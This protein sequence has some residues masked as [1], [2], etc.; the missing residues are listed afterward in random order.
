M[1]PPFSLRTALILGLGFLGITV[2]E[3]IFNIF[4]PLFLKEAGLSATVVGF[5]MTWDNYINMVVQPVAG[6]CSDRTRTRFGRRKPW[7]LVGAP[8]AAIG[9]ALLPVLP[10][11]AGLM[12]C[13]LAT[14][15]ALALFRSPAV[16]LLGDLFPPHQRS[17]ANGLIN[18]MGGVGAIL[19]FL[20]GGILYRL[21]RAYPFVFGSAVM[22]AMLL[23]V[24][25]LI[26]EPTAPGEEEER[27]ALWPLLAAMLRAPQR[28]LLRL[29]T[30]LL[31]LTVGYSVLQA[32]LSS[33][34][35]FTLGI[36]AD[37]TSM[38]ASLMALTFV[39]CAYPSGLL[40][41]R[42]GRKRVI[43]AG[44]LGL[45]VLFAYGLLVRSE[46]M[47]LLLLLPV[48]LFWALINIHSLPLVY[49]VGGEMR[50]GT[51]T[52]LY[53]LSGSLA[54]VTGPLLVGGL[55]DLT[56]GSYR[57]MFVVCGAFTLLAGLLLYGLREPAT[58]EAQKA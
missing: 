41:T 40:A 55:I 50:I 45:T 29:L 46:T 42:F 22:V 11:L 39:V 28:P 27:S 8:I 7:I 58:G 15:F 38:L 53:Y 24:V 20:A 43:L 32:W 48:G 57:V 13:I 56:G 2:G 5:V 3:P 36:P 4:V 18:L 34:A 9:F 10:T 49:D 47:L 44:T 16:S 17:A 26:R 52:G 33:F 1:R 37:R 21:G 31:C 35:R 23:L 51:L 25:W 6:A 12:A 19:G 30:A 14:N 54:L